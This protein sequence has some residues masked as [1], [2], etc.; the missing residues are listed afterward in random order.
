MGCY[1]AF[2]GLLRA[3]DAVGANVDRLALVLCLEL[4]SVHLQPD[5]SVENIVVS[6]LFGDGAAAAIIGHEGHGTGEALGPGDARGPRLVD[7]ATHCDY[8]T[9]DKMA[10]HVTDT[11]Y[12]MRLSA[13]VPDL[14]AAKIEEF[15]DGLLE[16]NNLGRD[17]VRFWGIHPGGAK[18]LDYLQA[19]LKLTDDDLG[20]SRK[21]LREHGNMSSPTILFVLEEI[22]R[23]GRPQRGDWGVL[24]AFGPGLTMEAA[25]LQW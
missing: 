20:Y 7:A 13:Y 8:T 23:C 25:L 12:Q 3:R 16:R 21:V 1:A 2:P 18:I 15:I 14:L 5:N 17:D 4:C 11:G 24:M 6:A 22:Q 9:L 10:F 19:R